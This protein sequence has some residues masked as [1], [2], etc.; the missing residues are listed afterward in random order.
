MFLESV[1]NSKQNCTNAAQ[2]GLGLGLG[3]DLGLGL[4]LSST[5]SDLK[6]LTR[7]ALH[8]CFH[9][10]LRVVSYRYNDIER[11]WK[12]AIFVDDTAFR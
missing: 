9:R 1:I 7:C 11:Y 3:L 5:W 2:W 4:G 10:Y 8:S 6:A 12:L